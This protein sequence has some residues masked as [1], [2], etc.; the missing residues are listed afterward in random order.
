MGASLGSGGN[1]RR[2]RSSRADSFSEINITPMVDVMLVLL[3]I[4]MVAAPMMTSGVTVDLP[5]ANSSP[6]AG[7]DEPLAVSVDSNGRVYIQKT[8]VQIKDL[9][10]KL[11][12]IIGQKK[13]T[14][15]F[16]RGDKNV[17]YGKMMQVVGEINAAGFSKV[18]LITDT[19][20]E[21]SSE[22]K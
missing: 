14:R 3:I 5:K 22:K 12:A 9:Q 19:G 2:R 18:A 11:I 20:G 4:F 1:N 10:A 6:V 16:V 8:Q 17:D 7:Q 13:D 21:K 15:I